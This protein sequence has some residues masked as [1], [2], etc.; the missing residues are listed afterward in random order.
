[1]SIIAVDT[2]KQHTPIVSFLMMAHSKIY[3]SS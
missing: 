1:M 2:N 3:R